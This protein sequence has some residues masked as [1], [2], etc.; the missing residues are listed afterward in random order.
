METEVDPTRLLTG[1]MVE[2]D[3]FV[4]RP[5]LYRLVEPNGTDRRFEVPGDIPFELAL[6]LPNRYDD[7]MAATQTDDV[8]REQEMEAAWG[9]LRSVLD[10]IVQILDP[11][12]SLGDFGYATLLAFSS[13]LIARLQLQQSGLSLEGFLQRL[14]ESLPEDPEAP[15]ARTS[16]RSSG[17]SARSS[18]GRTTT[19]ARSAGKSSGLRPV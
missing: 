1:S 7:L 14:L 5:T 13:A 18:G 19:G 16:S 9:R 8:V 2:L 3:A 17:R 15:K 12:A 4:P 6:A 10:R 11:A